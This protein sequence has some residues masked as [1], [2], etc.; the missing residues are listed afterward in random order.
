MLITLQPTL[1]TIHSYTAA[2]SLINK[3]VFL[4]HVWVRLAAQISGPSSFHYTILVVI[5]L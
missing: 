1:K 2:M 3:P 4:L 5:N